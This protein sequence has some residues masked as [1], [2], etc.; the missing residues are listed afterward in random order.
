MNANLFLH[1]EIKS[2]RTQNERKIKKRTRRNA[3]LGTDTILSV[4]EGQNHFQQLDSEVN[5][6][7]DES[8][9]RSR[10]RAPQR[11][12]GCGTVG[13]TIRV[14]PNKQLYFYTII[15][16]NFMV[17][18]VEWLQECGGCG[19][20]PPLGRVRRSVMD[21][22]KLVQSALSNPFFGSLW[23]HSFSSFSS[24]QL[25]IQIVLYRHL[26][27]FL[28]FFIFLSFLVIILPIP[29]RVRDSALLLLRGSHMWVSVIRAQSEDQDRTVTDKPRSGAHVTKV[30][31][32]G[33]N[34]W[35][36]QGDDRNNG[37][38]NYIDYKSRDVVHTVIHMM[39]HEE[40]PLGWIYKDTHSCTQFGDSRSI[41]LIKHWLHFQ[42]DSCALN[43]N[44]SAQL[45]AQSALFYSCDLYPLH[46]QLPQRSQ[47]GAIYQAPQY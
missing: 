43:T 30:Q 16:S 23:L 19:R 41:Q 9:P 6:Q 3:T 12:S 35:I 34:H 46:H 10:K 28:S 31:V 17:L 4:Q 44:D 20:N 21:Y 45:R 18:V 29:H 32:I 37:K 22:V 39:D 1:Q 36:T 15:Q 8:T 24:P 40:G 11:C 5:R 25:C 42:F 38:S 26:Y 33:S 14:C 27:H 13:H 2:L 7:V 47:A